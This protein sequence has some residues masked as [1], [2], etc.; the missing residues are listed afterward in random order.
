MAR[1]L[2]DPEPD[3]LAMR[4]GFFS[5]ELPRDKK[6]SL[7][8]VAIHE[9]GHGALADAMGLVIDVKIAADHGHVR[10]Q[11]PVTKDEDE[12]EELAIIALGGIVAETIASGSH[13]VVGHRDDLR[14]VWA[15][16]AARHRDE[17]ARAS[18]IRALVARTRQLLL[19]RWSAVERLA[20]RLMVDRKIDGLVARRVIAGFDNEHTDVFVN[21][22]RAEPWLL[23]G[24]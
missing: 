2:V 24:W 1:R 4:C 6:R 18:A 9:S 17:F 21:A 23:V 13:A 3:E 7:P 5:L 19:D 12:A 11:L 16:L 20:G 10:H 8:R 14:Q 15:L 22:M